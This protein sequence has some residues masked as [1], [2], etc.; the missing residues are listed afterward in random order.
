MLG[1]DAQELPEEGT[2]SGKSSDDTVCSEKETIQQQKLFWIRNAR[3]RLFIQ[4]E[5]LSCRDELYWPM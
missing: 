2:S 1:M 4:K 3:I 5:R